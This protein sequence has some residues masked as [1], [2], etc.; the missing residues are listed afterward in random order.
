L[1]ALVGI[2]GY[3]S[4]SDAV[5]AGG[6]PPGS[7]GHN[8]AIARGEIV[9]QGGF[10][11]GDFSEWHGVQAKSS[12]ATIVESPVREGR[13]AARF[14]VSPGDE[15]F[16]SHGGDRAESVLT[17]AQTDGY[18]GQEQWWAWSIMFSPGFS[19]RA[20]SDWNYFTQFHHTGS[21]GQVNVHFSANGQ[22]MTFVVCN[23]VPQKSRCRKWNIDPDRVN[24]RWYDFV[25]HVRWSSSRKRGFVELWENGVSVVPF[26]RIATLYPGQ[27]V[28]L[29]QGIY[30]TPQPRTSAIY[31]DGTRWGT[32]YPSVVDEFPAGEWPAQPPRPKRTKPPSPRAPAASRVSRPAT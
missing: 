7:G 30:R 9:W 24:S 5:A 1:L 6:A 2:S 21:T 10:E 28:Y 18:E 11:T 27:G 20:D 17:Q 4:T 31:V 23:G 12:G 8:S 13:Y 29:K 3:S 15:A 14:R 19:S 22:V 32:G 25:F 16:G 26:T